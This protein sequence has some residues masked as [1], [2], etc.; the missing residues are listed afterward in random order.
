MGGAHEQSAVR[1]M[2]G[3]GVQRLASHESQIDKLAAACGLD[4]VEI[5]LLR[6]R[7]GRPLVTERL[8]RGAH[9]ALP[10]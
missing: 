2:R 1:A 6:D 7:D 10:A 4:P 3:F 8:E 5:R 9:G